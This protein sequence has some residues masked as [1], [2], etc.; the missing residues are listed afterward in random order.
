MPNFSTIFPVTPIVLD[1][2]IASMLH[3]IQSLKFLQVPL[4]TPCHKIQTNTVGRPLTTLV[5]KAKHLM[6]RIE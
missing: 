5:V 1:L 3:Q 6:N 4:V 2:T